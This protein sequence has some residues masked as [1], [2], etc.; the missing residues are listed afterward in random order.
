MRLFGIRDGIRDMGYGWD[1]D[2]GLGWDFGKW[3]GIL[4]KGMGYGMGWDRGFSHPI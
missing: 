3:E 4:A 2:L 1:W